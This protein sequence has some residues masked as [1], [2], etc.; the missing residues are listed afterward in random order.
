[1]MGAWTWEM[2]PL[3]IERAAYEEFVR[4]GVKEALSISDWAKRFTTTLIYTNSPIR[5]D[6]TISMRLTVIKTHA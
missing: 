6:Y 5:P 1:M 4:F 3:Q 2:I